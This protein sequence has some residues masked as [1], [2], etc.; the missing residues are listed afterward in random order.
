MYMNHNVLSAELKKKAEKF[1]AGNISKN[2]NAL[3][4]IE[5]KKYFIRTHGCT[6]YTQY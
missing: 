2:I 5:D 3:F 1:Q 6:A 4:P